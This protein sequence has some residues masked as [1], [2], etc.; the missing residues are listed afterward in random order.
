VE[1]RRARCGIVFNYWRFAACRQSRTN[2]YDDEDMIDID[3]HD[4]AVYDHDQSQAPKQGCGQKTT[5][6]QRAWAW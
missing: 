1:I 5:T 6:P 4:A 3:E 2:F